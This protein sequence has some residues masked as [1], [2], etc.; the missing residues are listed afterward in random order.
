M[1]AGKAGAYPSEAPFRS[2]TL[3]LAPAWVTKRNEPICVTL[4]K[5]VKQVGV[6]KGD[7]G[8]QRVTKG[9][10]RWQSV[11]KGDKGWQRVAKGD[12]GWQR[13]TKGDKGWQRVTK[14]AEVASW[15]DKHFCKRAFFAKKYIA[16]TAILVWDHNVKWSHSCAINCTFQ[17][18]LMSPLLANCCTQIW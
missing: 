14:G 1:F 15:N 5:Q 16:L 9:D 3:G 7:K 13:V 18:F 17:V 6:T 2:S 10:K 8:W 11:T 4:P 12:K